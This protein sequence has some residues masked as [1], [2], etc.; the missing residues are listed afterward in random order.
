MKFITI[1]EL[2][3]KMKKTREIISK[4]K[5]II[6][7]RGKPIAIIRPLGEDNFENA[8]ND[9]VATYGSKIT[10]KDLMQFKKSVEALQKEAKKRGITQKDVDEAVLAV[11]AEMRAERNA[12]N[13]N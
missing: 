9:P 3:T 10:K 7:W 8:V 2:A 4:E 12:K 5:V 6:T 13:S 11:R 1:K